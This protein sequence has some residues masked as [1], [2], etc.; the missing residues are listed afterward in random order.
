MFHEATSVIYH[1]LLASNEILNDWE[2]ERLRNWLMV[3]CK[4]DSAADAS[5]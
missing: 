4:S 1:H 2:P 5:Q 3:S